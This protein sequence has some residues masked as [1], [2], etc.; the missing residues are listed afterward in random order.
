MKRHATVITIAAVMA[1]VLTGCSGSGIAYDYDL[2]EYVTVGNYTGIDYTAINVEVTDEE[3]EDEIEKVLQK[4]SDQKE[5][6]EGTIKKGDYVG[7]SYELEVEGEKVEG[8]ASQDYT[9]QVGEGQILEDIDKA[10][11]GKELGDKFTVE[12]A[13][14]E[15][16]ELS[17]EMAG[18]D[19]TF[20]ITVAKLYDVKFPEFNNAFVAK[21]LGFET[22]EA[23]KEDLKNSL[24]E[25]KL[26]TAEYNAGEEIWAKVLESSEVIK[27][28]EKEVKAKQEELTKNFKDLCGQYGMTFESAL[29]SVLNTDEESFNEEMKKSAE[30][31]V[32][33]EMILYAI[34]RENDLELSKEEQQKYLDEVLE[35]NEMTAK[36]FKNQ[37]SMSIEEYAEESG[38]MISLLYDRVFDFLRENGVAK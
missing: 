12:T 15:D 37:Y 1:M 29:E 10:L 2:A 20:Q 27:Y 3:I 31:A 35:E 7:I 23:Y 25:D 38:I 4:Y 26:E 13:F 8:T 28:P 6:T 34:A 36:E 22:V 21:N 5:L 14:P 18:K 11:V 17:E 24:Y 33:E 32:K 30:A 9:I 16:Y 19:A